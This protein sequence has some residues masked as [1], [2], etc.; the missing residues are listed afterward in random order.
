ML[1]GSTK[2]VGAWPLPKVMFT[3]GSGIAMFAV[4][5][6]VSSRVLFEPAPKKVVQEAP[7]SFVETLT[8]CDR[9]NSCVR[10]RTGAV[11]TPT[12]VTGTRTSLVVAEL[13]TQATQGQGVG[14]F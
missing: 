5:L 1:G 8:D 13:V 9:S 2:P 12:T 6:T 7:V 4:F 11:G 10:C 14:G 3:L